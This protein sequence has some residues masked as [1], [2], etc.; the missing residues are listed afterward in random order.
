MALEEAG[1]FLVEEELLLFIDALADVRFAKPAAVVGQSA[2]LHD[3]GSMHASASA[4]EGLSPRPV[5]AEAL[6]DLALMTDPLDGSEIAL[7][8]FQEEVLLAAGHAVERVLS[9][10]VPSAFADLQDF[11]DCRIA[12]A[13]K[14]LLGMQRWIFQAWASRI[15]SRRSPREVSRCEEL[16]C[17]QRHGGHSP[18]G[19][20]PSPPLSP[21]SETPA[22]SVQSAMPSSG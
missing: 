21:R 12:P 6:R 10:E 16:Q 22:C 18:A 1:L 4:W 15:P 17:S 8:P 3:S 11:I 20:A 7:T 13:S 19:S 2:S 14:L 9:D 5:L